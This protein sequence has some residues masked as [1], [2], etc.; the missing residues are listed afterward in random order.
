[1]FEPHVTGVAW[2]VGAMGNAVWR[3]VRLKDVLERA[4]IKANALEVV[5]DGADRGELDKTPDFVKSLPLD[6]AM[7]EEP[8][9]AFEMNG[10][11]LPHWNGYPVRLVVPG[12]TGTY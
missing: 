3:G 4:G 12:W 8:L 6:V 11:P 2:G 7:R 5:F 1:L 9:I 10:E